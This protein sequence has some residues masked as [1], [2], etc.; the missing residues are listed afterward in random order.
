M[1]TPTA[2][3][4]LAM[5]RAATP[6]LTSEAPDDARGIYRLFNCTLLLPSDICASIGAK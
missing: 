2:A 4:I 5:L 1:T 6:R 3:E